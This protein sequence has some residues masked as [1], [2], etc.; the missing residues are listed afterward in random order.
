MMRSRP[1]GRVFRGAIHVAT[2][3][4]PALIVLTVAA[5]LAVAMAWAQ[6]SKAPNRTD[7]DGPQSAASPSAD[8]T[9]ESRD[10]TR[11][12]EGSELVNQIGY[13]RMTGDRVT[14]FAEGGKGRFVVLENS[15]LDRISRIIAESPDHMKW[16]VTATVT[17]FQGENYFF[18]RKAI[19]RNQREPEE[20]EYGL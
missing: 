3:G 8:G 12:R 18:I 9:S 17:E 19:L 20:D 13:F 5:A 11:I 4:R 7:P 14:F 16:S 10:D 6:S 2:G 1:I 15:N